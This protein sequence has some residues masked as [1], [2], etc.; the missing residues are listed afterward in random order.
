M[1]GTHAGTAAKL[2]LNC[3]GQRD[4]RNDC[5]GCLDL[6][7]PACCGGGDRVIRLPDGG[8]FHAGWFVGL[9]A[10]VLCEVGFR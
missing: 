10:S 7:Q 2:R 3:H 6:H 1:R 4:L 8:V 5:P 9:G